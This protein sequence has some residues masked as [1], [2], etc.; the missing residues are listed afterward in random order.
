MKKTTSQNVWNSTIER[1][2]Y[3]FN[4]FENV[5]ISFSGGKDSGVCI[6]ILD[7]VAQQLK[8]TYDVLFIDLEGQYNL[9]IDFIKEVSDLKNINKFYWLCLPIVLRNAV[10]Q[11]QPRWIPWDNKAKEIWI[12]ELPSVNEK[13]ILIHENNVANFFPWFKKGQEFEELII[14]FSKWYEKDKGKVAAIIAIRADESFHRFCTLTNDKKI[15]YKQKDWS[16]FIKGSKHTYNFYP[17]YDWKTRDIWIA[18][19]NKNLLWNKVYDLMYKNGLSIH[20]QRLCQP[21]GDDQKNGLDQ[22]R[23]IEPETW[24]KLLNRVSGVNFGN[25]YCRTS[26]LGNI[27][28][29]KPEHL[30]WEE[31][32]IFLLET[33]YFYNKELVEHYVIKIEK[34]IKWYEIKKGVFLKDI[35][36]F[37][38]SKIETNK[39]MITWRR[40]ARAIER[41]DWFLK[42]LCFGQTKNDIEKLYIFIDKYNNM[43]DINNTNDKHLKKL[44]GE[45]WKK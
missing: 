23:Y 41:N 34:F 3:I 10:S 7:L 8:R 33:L 18:T 14:D 4:N 42:R 21:Y 20:E 2:K 1:I 22:F 37:L 38:D 40:I 13:T 35:P 32:T 17:I 6:Q 26:L 28:S 5:Y 39:E 11:F 43:L 24:E 9:T 36:Q 25:I 45:I 30:N 27:K 16:T 44:G 29:E 31:Y 15:R 19:F 12:R